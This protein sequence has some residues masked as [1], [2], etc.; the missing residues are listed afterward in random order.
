[1]MW[2]AAC[3][4]GTTRMVRSCAHPASRLCVETVSSPWD[5]EPA[6]PAAL[7]EDA[8]AVA[9]VAEHDESAGT[10]GSCLGSRH[11]CELLTPRPQQRWLAPTVQWMRPLS[12]LTSRSGRAVSD[13]PPTLRAVS[14]VPSSRSHLA[15]KERIAVRRRLCASINAARSLLQWGA[16][17]APQEA[18]VGPESDLTADLD[19]PLRAVSKKLR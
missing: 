17:S 5:A 16:A 3:L 4:A 9:V 12:H 2:T 7:G 6:E 19:G 18:P 8:A 13:S 10:P 1:M 14:C 11:W 15:G